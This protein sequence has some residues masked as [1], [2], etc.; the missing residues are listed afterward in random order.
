MSESKKSIQIIEVQHASAVAAIETADGPRAIIEAG[1]VDALA[2]SGAS[3]HLLQLPSNPLEGSGEVGKAFAVARQVA[4]AVR[5]A[6]DRGRTPIVLSGSCHTALGSVAG[7]PSGRRGVI[8]LDCHADFNTPDTTE[9]GLL[10]GM[11]LASITGRCWKGL[12]R[13]VSGFEPI[14]D[15][16]VVLV[17]AREFDASEERLLAEAAVSRVSSVDVRTGNV[18]PLRMLAT[19][20]ASVYVHIDLDVLDPSVGMAN[21]FATAGGLRVSDLVD[22]LEKV[23][24]SFGRRVVGMTSYDPREDKD[25]S[26]AS[27]AVRGAAT[28]AV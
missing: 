14:S 18:E 28:I 24:A 25:G 22:F 21:A 15:T 3:V 12:A 1:L 11:V 13:S 4:S 5:G 9:S 27:A 17:G 10:D 2:S 26:I 6:L 8:W 19:Q 7:L 23:S 20:V 16:D